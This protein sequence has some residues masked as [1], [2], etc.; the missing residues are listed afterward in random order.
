LD[1]TPGYLDV[2]QAAVTSR[3]SPLASSSYIGVSLPGSEQRER[4]N[5]RTAGR[6]S[7]ELRTGPNGRSDPVRKLPREVGTGGG[8]GLA[9]CG[10][11]VGGNR[12]VRGPAPARRD[13]RLCVFGDVAIMSWRQD[14]QGGKRRPRYCNEGRVTAEDGR[15]LPGCSRVVARRRVAEP[16]GSMVRG[17]RQDETLR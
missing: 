6:T 5:R 4:H 7:A 11:R 9:V 12:L 14:I 3:G 1:V 10:N 17:R 15:E 2:T 8:A 16:P 13:G